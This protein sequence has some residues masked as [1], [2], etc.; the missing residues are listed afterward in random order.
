MNIHQPRDTPAPLVTEPVLEG[1]F[2]RL[3]Y[4]ALVLPVLVVGYVVFI[5]AGR[6]LTFR[7]RVVR[8][9]LYAMVFF[10]WHG[11]RW[12]GLAASQNRR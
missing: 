2:E 5:A 3:L 8:V 4:Y 10:E 11:G 12:P 1:L 7:A 6:F 9:M